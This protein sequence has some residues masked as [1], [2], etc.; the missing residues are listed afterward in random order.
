[1]DKENKES[2]GVGI[3]EFLG[4]VSRAQRSGYTDIYRGVFPEEGGPS[5]L[6]MIITKLVESGES[7][8]KSME[9][10]NVDARST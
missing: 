10:E 7:L 6:S 5:L 9:A 2:L 1:M 3:A 4:K 8:D